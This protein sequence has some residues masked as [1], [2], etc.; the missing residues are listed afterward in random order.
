MTGVV[1]GMGRPSTISSFTGQAHE[2][3]CFWRWCFLSE[4]MQVSGEGLSQKLAVLLVA[5]KYLERVRL[6]KNQP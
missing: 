3:R 4:S 1:L 6:D 5:L 2:T